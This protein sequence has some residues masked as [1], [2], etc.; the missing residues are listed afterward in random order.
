M[1]WTRSSHSSRRSSATAT[2]PSVNVDGAELLPQLGVV[3]V[4]GD[5]LDQPA[6]PD[7]EDEQVRQGE[8]PP[9]VA[10]RAPL[11]GLGAAHD[12]LGRDVAVTVGD[13]GCHLL[14]HVGA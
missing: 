14:R 9:P 2:P 7:P 12:Y 3:P 11:A 6:V 10:G 13:D 1:S 8:P 4:G 5:P